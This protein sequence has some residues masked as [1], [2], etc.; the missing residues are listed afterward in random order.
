M[1]KPYVNLASNYKKCTIKSKNDYLEL[2]Y[3][4]PTLVNA[5]VGI[6]QT[7]EIGHEQQKII[8]ISCLKNR[9][10]IISDLS[11]SRS[12]RLWDFILKETPCIAGT[13]PIYTVKQRNGCIDQNELLEIIIDQIESGVGVITIHLTP[14]RELYELSRNRLVPC[15]SR[16]GALVLRDLIATNWQYDNVYL[17]ILS[18]IISI[19][20][21]HGTVISL[22]ASF[23]SANIIE[24][25]D[26]VQ[27]KEIL[28]QLQL[29]DNIYKQGVGVIIESPGHAP[30]V[31]I[32]KIADILRPSGF[33]IMPLGPI[34]TDIAIGMDHI[35]GAIGATLL[36]LEGAA[37]LLTAVT[38]K[39]HI[40]G[41]P[42]L[43]DTVEAIESTKIAA[44]IIDLYKIGD[45]AQD[46][47]ITNE[48]A[49]YKTCI[50]G[51]HFEGC[52][53]CGKNCPLK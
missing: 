50:Y 42:S 45:V 12:S 16:G 4:T 47:L 36:G 23:R 15:T 34:P 7:K 9:P 33:P 8:T 13:L 11:Q 1:Y 19:A 32:Q 53:R 3:L 25:L 26:S 30:P 20:R 28:A 52:T 14:T 35:S 37:H 44:H 46:F 39:E 51:N 5:L 22:G 27:Q 48:R 49:L 2:N 31:N 29:G 40:G 43:T 21:K 38:R 10:D 41:I 6:N 18:D 17:R 24:S